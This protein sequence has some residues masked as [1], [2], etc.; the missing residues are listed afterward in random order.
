MSVLRDVW[1]LNHEYFSRS[2]F[3][4]TVAILMRLVQ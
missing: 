3:I 2:C 4:M 1:G